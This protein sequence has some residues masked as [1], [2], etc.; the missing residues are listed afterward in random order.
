MRA[1]C[2]INE[3]ADLRGNQSTTAMAVEIAKR[4]GAWVAGLTDVSLA[5]DGTVV[6][7]AL[8]VEATSAGDA[9]ARARQR[10]PGRGEIPGDRCDP[11]PHQ[12]GTRQREDRVP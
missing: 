11:H 4:G 10:E 9:A 1:L 3:R 7:D 2:L 8:P 6:F 12:P 5:P